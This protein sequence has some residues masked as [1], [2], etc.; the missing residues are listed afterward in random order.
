MN[1]IPF[2]TTVL[3]GGGG[4]QGPTIEK[5]KIPYLVRNIAYALE[6]TI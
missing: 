5:Q 3:R 4:V 1:P 6:C 2:Y